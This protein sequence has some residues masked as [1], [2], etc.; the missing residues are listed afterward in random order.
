MGYENAFEIAGK[1]L[2]DVILEIEKVII[3]KRNIIE[4]LMIC[5]AARG[6]ILIEDMPGVGKTTIALALAKSSNL[7]YKRIQFTPDTMPSDITGFNIYNREKNE[8]E[9]KAGIAVCNLLLADEINRTVPKTQSSLLE[10]M[11]EG[12][13]TVDGVAHIVPKPFMVIATQNPT[14]FVGTHTLPEAQL[15]RFL[16][17]VSIGYPSIDEEFAIISDRQNQNPLDTVKS[18]ITKGDIENI[19]NVCGEVFLDDSIKRYIVNIVA[20]TRNNKQI[21]FGASPRA[22]IALM[23]T[24]QATALL[25]GREYVIPED[26]VS[27]A[28]H[29]LSHRIMLNSE[30]RFEKVSSSSLISQLIQKVMP[31]YY[32][33]KGRI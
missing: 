11:E 23:R 32:N 30:L 6:H 17:K 16:M 13:V 5:L 4:L 18:I 26:V 15:D 9:Y 7:E 20:E 1:T 24:S 28:S 3:G 29:V 10:V 8:F 12:V 14:G 25:K 22:S 2:N 19:Q 21:K 33:K 27:V 31:P